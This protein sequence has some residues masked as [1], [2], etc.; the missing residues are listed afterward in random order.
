MGW[1]L[2][3]DKYRDININPYKFMYA[4]LRFRSG[5]MLIL[6]DSVASCRIFKIVPYPHFMY[7]IAK[8]YRIIYKREVTDEKTDLL[9][10]FIPCE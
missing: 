1:I 5:C 4:T 3:S 7:N 10:A 8:V 9:K 6:A 2:I